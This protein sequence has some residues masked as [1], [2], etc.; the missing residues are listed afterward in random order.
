MKVW[1]LV[2]GILCMVFF[3]IVVLQSCA[4]GVVNSIDENTADTSAAGGILLAVLMLAGGIVSVVTRK[5]GRGGS[6]ATL[7]IFLIAA[8]MGF[9]NK[10]TYG[11]LVIWAGWCAICAVMSLVG[12]VVSGKKTKSNDPSNE[13][14]TD[15]AA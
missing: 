5:G 15:E 1:K 10:G 13:P 6:I 8:L 4:V 11:D 2:S 7:V 9:A 14:S 12:V 3:A